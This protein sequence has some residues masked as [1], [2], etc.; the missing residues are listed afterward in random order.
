[1]EAFYFIECSSILF[2]NRV[3]GLGENT[4]EV[5]H[6]LYQGA[7]VSHVITAS[8]VNFNYLVEV[9]SASFL[10]CEVTFF[11]PFHTLCFGSELLSPANLKGQELGF[12]S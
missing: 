3:K 11:P 4:G 1:M 5:K 6:A 8:D 12:T 7:H 10:H 9:V 2:C